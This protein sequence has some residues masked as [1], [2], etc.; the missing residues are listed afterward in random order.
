MIIRLVFIEFSFFRL[1]LLGSSHHKSFKE[2]AT[3]ESIMMTEIY[4]Y[5]CT[6]NDDKFSIVEFQP[7]K[8]L[9]ATRM[10]DYGYHLKTLMYM[11]QISIH[12]QKDPAKYTKDFLDKVKYF[13]SILCLG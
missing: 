6:L 3:N 7:Y 2:F 5:A 10:L 9:L 1:I 4:E 11:E 8:Y 12:V 13:H